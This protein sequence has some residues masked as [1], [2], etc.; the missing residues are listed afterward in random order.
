MGIRIWIMLAITPLS[1]LAQQKNPTM[2]EQIRAVENSLAPDVVYGDR[3]PKWNLEE[4]MRTA[5]VKGLGIAVIKDYQILWTKGYGWADEASGR[6]VTPTTRFQAASISKSIN[7]LGLLKLVEQGKLDPE[8]DINTYLKRWKFPYDS[9]SEG[10]KITLHHLLSH[11]AGLD[12]H[13]FPGYERGDSLPTIQQILDGQSPANTRKVRS[14]LA[15]GEIV[16][17]SGGG[18]TISQLMLMDITGRDYAEFMRAEVLDPLGM[19]HSS[20]VQPPADTNELA[21][22]YYRNGQPV[23]GKYHVYPEQAAAGLW[24]TPSDLARYVI[25]CQLAYAGKSKKVLSRDMMRK[26]MTPYID[27]AAAQGVFIVNKNG[28][29]YFNHNGGNEAF[30][31]TSY[32]SLEGG[33]GVV[34]MINGE[35]FG[36][37]RELMNSVATVYQWKD[38]Y[39]PAFK[40]LVSLSQAQM[41][42]YTGDYRLGKDDSLQVSVC[43]KELCIRQ[44]AQPAPGFTLLFTDETHFEIAEVPNASFAVLKNEQGG[45]EALELTQN[46]M[47]QKLLKIR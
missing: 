37:I 38:F 6:K 28:N 3:V 31:C 12:V 47:K 41:L 8:A 7:S 25:E 16:K 26:R 44:G 30:L 4:R 27:S 23:K 43:G 10:K 14:L 24:T 39:T 2:Q 33:N 22:G 21:T 34:I 40:K 42:A 32:G 15:P 18:T 36:V 17:Y 9:L 11:T 35:N 20:F 5:G 19:K 46:G 1:L 45:V 29:R 13:G